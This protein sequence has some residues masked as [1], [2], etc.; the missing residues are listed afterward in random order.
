MTMTDD[1]AVDPASLPQ[2][3]EQADP[4][5]VVDEDPTDAELT[6]DETEETDAETDPDPDAETGEDEAEE[7]DEEAEEEPETV[8]IERDGKKYTVPAELKDAFMLQSDYTQKTQEVAEQRKALE[9]QAAE[10]EQSMERRQALAMEHAQ[11]EA[12]NLQLSRFDNVDWAAAQA[13]DP[14]QANAAF[15]QMQQMRNTADQLSKNIQEKENQAALEKQRERAKQL[16]QGR[17]ELQRD[18][19]GYSPE[20]AVQL[21]KV[22][23][24]IGFTNAELAEVNHDARYAKVLHYAKIGLE[25]LEK[26]KQARKKP[27]AKQ[28]PAEPAAEMPRGGRPRN[29]T[30]NPE[31]MSTE[32]WM[33]HRQKQLQKRRA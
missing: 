11:L 18:I 3:G 2:G 30:P 22:A 15:M 28:A 27:K 32:Q 5:A 10:F 16:E 26:Q 8:E 7:T 24:D 19:P 29:A 12:I 17:Q 25:T 23:Q 33:N 31:R 13:Q 4:P 20:Y 9:A 14:E 21:G 1:Q 6:E